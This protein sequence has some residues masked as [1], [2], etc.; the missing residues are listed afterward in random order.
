MVMKRYNELAVGATVGLRR[1]IRA[2]RVD[3]FSSLNGLTRDMVMRAIKCKVN[4]ATPCRQA[5]NRRE[6]FP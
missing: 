1:I 5:R 4:I 2:I 6:H 3:A